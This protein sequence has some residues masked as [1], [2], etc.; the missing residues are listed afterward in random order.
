LES[1][2]AKNVAA[3]FRHSAEH[4]IAPRCRARQI[5]DDL[6][7]SF[8]LRTLSDRATSQLTLALASEIGHRGHDVTVLSLNRGPG[9]PTYVDHARLQDLG[10]GNRISP[11]SIRYL[12]KWMRRAQP[13]TIFCQGP[14]PGRAAVIAQ[15]LSPGDC[16]LI[17]TDHNPPTTKFSKLNFVLR[18]ADVLAAPS[19][20][21]ALR[22]EARTGARNVAV[23]PDPMLRSL[24]PEPQLPDRWYSDGRPIVCSVANII[25]RKGH[26]ILIRALATV[27][28]RL[29]LVGRFDDRDYFNQLQRL[30]REID[31][32]HRVWFVGYRPD[33]LPFMYHAD[34]FALASRSES[35][36][37][38]LTEA[39][40]CGVPVVATDCP[41]GPRYVVDDGKAGVLVAPDNP[42][43]M[44]DG[45]RLVLGDEATRSRLVA[46]GKRAAGLLSVE[47]IA[48]R[49]LALVPASPHRDPATLSLN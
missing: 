37:M 42:A 23:L 48:D 6:K 8:L 29:V 43:A 24:E 25:P 36:A 18:K 35:F 27:D 2:I 46:A 47:R 17:V 30:A 16:S 33:P 7:I 14:G 22:F 44:A 9:A 26:D 49:Y 39:M 28:A 19:P 32:L 12:A 5:S 15:Q 41:E 10:V 38:V 45:L 34:V 13:E 1:W 40:A 3:S 11:R 31:V 4:P 21:A 20:S